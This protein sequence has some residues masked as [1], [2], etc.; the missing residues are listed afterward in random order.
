MLS[1]STY[2]LVTIGILSWNRLH[3]LRAAIDSAQRCIHYPELEWIVS[4]NESEEPGLRDYLVGLEGIDHKIF[5]RQS[6][7]AAMNQIVEMASGDL[8]MLLPDDVQFVVQGN[9]LH[10]MVELLQAHDWIGSIA[11]DFM[12]RQRNQRQ[13]NRGWSAHVRELILHG[14]RWRRPRLVY[15]SNCYGLSTLGNQVPGIAPAGILSLTR[16]S[17]WQQL[18]PWR[19]AP[20]GVDIDI[21]DSS[22]GAED[23]M[24]VRFVESGLPLQRA[25]PLL[26]VAASIL[27][28]PSG[29][30]AKVRGEYR[31][32][33][34]KPPAK[35]NLYYRVWQQD[36]LTNKIKGRF[37]LP[38]EDWV[39]PL[40]GKLPLDEAGNLLKSS[41]NMDIVERVEL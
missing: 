24:F 35:G 37:P 1:P 29:T 31:Y 27:T 23:D 21:I 26:P 18:G 33:L 30:A 6:H 8:I 39:Q 5:E 41:I 19:E 15:S 2:P 12:R 40:D 16:K 4:D 3:Y 11:L 28:D 34:Y 36:Q 13:F 7:A 38:F 14:R 25:H 17:V 10:D 20:S 22:M 32:G 9:W